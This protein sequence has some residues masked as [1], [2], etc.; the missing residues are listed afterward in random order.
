LPLRTK[1]F[2]L[3]TNYILDWLARPALRTAVAPP[4]A[5]WLYFDPGI[6]PAG[7]PDAAGAADVIVML[8]RFQELAKA[9]PIRRNTGQLA[10][11]QAAFGQPIEL[12]ILVS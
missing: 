8:Q 6:S 9:L 12:W 11:A 2:E 7:Q 1:T 4:G 3:E 10:Q 5:D